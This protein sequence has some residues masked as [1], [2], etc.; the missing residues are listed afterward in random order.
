MWNGWTRTI[1]PIISSFFFCLIFYFCLIVFYFYRVT[2]WDV[3]RT[4]VLRSGTLDPAHPCITLPNAT[5]I[6]LYSVAKLDAVPVYL[7][8]LCELS[9]KGDKVTQGKV[10][11]W[12]VG[13]SVSYSEQSKRPKIHIIRAEYAEFLKSKSVPNTYSQVFPGNSLKFLL[14]G[15]LLYIQNQKKLRE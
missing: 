1:L 14:G 15:S 5:Q 4:L 11:R 10:S 12:L 2:F 9:S 6:P 7:C 8:C 13:V 3:I